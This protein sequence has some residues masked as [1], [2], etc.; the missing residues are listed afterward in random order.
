MHV[1][2]SINIMVCPLLLWGPKR[3]TLLGQLEPK[4]QKRRGQSSAPPKAGESKAVE[5]V[6]ECKRSKQE[7]SFGPSQGPKHGKVPRVTQL[8]MWEAFQGAGSEGWRQ[9]AS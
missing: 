9:E 2:R 3:T 5:S 7:E 4:D 8:R 6:E 1:Q